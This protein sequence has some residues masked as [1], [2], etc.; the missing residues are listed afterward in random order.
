MRKNLLLEHIADLSFILVALCWGSTFIII[1]KAIGHISVFNFLFY[2]FFLAS[3]L[4]SPFLLIKRRYLNKQSFY[5]GCFL[6]LLLFLLFA[7]QTI[8]LQYLKS[9]VAAFLTGSYIIFTPLFS[10]IILHKKPY[11][12]SIYGVIIAFIGL[13]LITY[14]KNFTINKGITLLILTAIFTALHLVFVDKYSRVHNT[15]IL[16]TIQFI[17]MAFL[18][19]FCIIFIDHNSLNF[20][21]NIYVLSAI[22]YTAVFAS[23]I[24]YL[25]QIGMQRYT[26]PTKTA[27]M[28]TA[29]PLS[30]PFFSY[31]LGGETLSLQQYFGAALII[32]SIII[33]ESGTSKKYGN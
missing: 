22:I 27:I 21:L 2:R 15:F 1:K 10:I 32:I 30:A 14:E 3:I 9:S 25:V 20:N 13:F 33:T 29:E 23:V 5:A 31:F 17:T 19:L 6:G 26:T 8:G 28:F 18:S 24:A 16:T 11:R 4:L 12:T 7:S